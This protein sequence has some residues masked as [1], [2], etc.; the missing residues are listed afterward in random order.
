MLKVLHGIN[1]ILLTA[2]TAWGFSLWNALPDRIPVH[3]GFDGTPDRWT[4]K[5]WELII[6]ILLP[7]IMTSLIYGL[8]ALSRRHT[9][10]LNI[11]D[12]D[13]LLAL[14]DAKQEPFWNALRE[15]MAGLTITINILFFTLVY[16]IS[17]T[18]QGLRKGLSPL[19]LGACG[20]VF[21]CI[22]I[23]I[24]RLRKAQKDCLS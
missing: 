18:A 22:L 2:G 8:T 11:P 24:V 15:F 16:D 3:F 19:F 6:L 10:L 1:A 17:R 20:L 7:F 12:K 13:K 9:W 4:E 21:L 23:N 14:P 5:G